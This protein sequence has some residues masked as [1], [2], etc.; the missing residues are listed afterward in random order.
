MVVQ[1]LVDWREEQIDREEDRF[2][3][4][5]YRPKSAAYTEG[6][7]TNQIASMVSGQTSFAGSHLPRALSHIGKT[8]DDAQSSGRDDTTSP[9]QRALFGVGY[10]YGR[11]KRI[12]TLRRGLCC[13]YFWSWI[14]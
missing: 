6:P 12:K 11:D 10:A 8:A 3:L 1:E 2:H 13:G 4:Q 5:I 9:V 14:Q 7:S